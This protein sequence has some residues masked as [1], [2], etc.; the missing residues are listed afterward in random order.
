M[1]YRISPMTGSIRASVCARWQV[2]AVSIPVISATAAALL[3]ARFGLASLLPPLFWAVLA[4]YAVITTAY[5]FVLK[6]KL[7]VDVFT[8][9][10]LYTAANRRRCRCDR[11]R[12]VILA[13][14]LLD[15]LFPQ[16]GAG[17]ALCRA[18]RTC[19]T[20]TMR[21]SRAAAMSASDK[22][23]I[24]QAGIA[25]AFS[26]AMVLALYVDS[27]EVASMYAQPWL[28]WPLCPLILYMLLR[29]WILARV[30]RC[31]TIRWSSSCATGAA[32]SPRL[33]GGTGHSG[34]AQVCE[35]NVSGVDSWGRV[36]RIRAERPRFQT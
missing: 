18:G 10:A 22:D 24:G 6:R 30:R 26:A 14:R 19:R 35:R 11:H 33:S 3:L 36:V 28:L 20:A 21:N 34:N 4:L 9:A 2:G 13:A 23:M 1:T 12:S 15:L 5:T 8:L 7:L 25:S 17:Q 31:M 32:R 27:N 29:I 16:P